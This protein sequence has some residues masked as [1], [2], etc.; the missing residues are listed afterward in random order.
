[1]SESTKQPGTS[2]RK[3]LT[4]TTAIS[5]R[6]ILIWMMGVVS[7][8]AIASGTTWQK[9]V[10]TLQ[11]VFIPHYN[12]PGGHLLHSFGQPWH[13][14]NSVAWSP[15]GTRVASASSDGTVQIW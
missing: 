12:L 11:A 3:N 9:F 10:H 4:P 13:P 14:I 7:A 2:P 1:M 6:T 15:D 5:R 8:E